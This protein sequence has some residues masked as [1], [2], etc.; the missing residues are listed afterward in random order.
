[1]QRIMII[2][3]PGSG[4]STLARNL[5]VKTGLPVHHMDHIHH[6]P[7]WAE[8]PKPEK[9]AMAHAIEAAP[10]WVFEGGLA[11][12]YDTRAAR[13]DLVV[14]LD[15]NVIN[16]LW[17]VLK[18]I[19]R[20]RGT[21][22]PDMAP[23]CPEQFAPDFLWWILTSNNKNRSRDTAFLAGLPSEKTL[24]LRSQAQIDAFVAQ[25]PPQKAST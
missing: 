6:L 23:G 1:M 3:A 17:R 5:G 22:R 21:V 14:F 13:A 25:F 4:K 10:E 19:W 24:T 15:L 20:Y 8:R 11:S 16:R 9:L 12:T 2:G 18:R 7:G